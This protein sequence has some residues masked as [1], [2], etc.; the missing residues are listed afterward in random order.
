MAGRDAKMLKRKAAVHATTKRQERPFY[1]AEKN[2]SHIALNGIGGY[3]LPI[4]FK[5]FQPDGLNNSSLVRASSFSKVVG[6]VSR[7]WMKQ[8][9]ALVSAAISFWADKGLHGKRQ[10]S[11]PATVLPPPPASLALSVPWSLLQDCS[12]LPSRPFPRLLCLTSGWTIF[13]F[14]S[15]GGLPRIGGPS[16]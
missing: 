7:A 3:L 13:C 8:S 11:R 10:V 2:Q 14:R 6:K 16:P 12:S 1:E 4:S 5:I 15:V 9:M